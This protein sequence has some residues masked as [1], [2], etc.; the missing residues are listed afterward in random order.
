[1][2][3]KRTTGSYELI[4]EDLGK[5]Q[6]RNNSCKILGIVSWGIG[7]GEKGIPSVYTKI[8]K[9]LRWIERGT[10]NAVYCALNL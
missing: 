1:M 5:R 8:T 6:R 7:C 3:Y 10:T 4:G 2:V 9:Y